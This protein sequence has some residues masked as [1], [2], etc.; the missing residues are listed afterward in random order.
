[1]LLK[2]QQPGGGERGEGLWVWCERGGEGLLCICCIERHFCR[3]NSK[4]L[5]GGQGE[6]ACVWEEGVASGGSRARGPGC[7][8]LER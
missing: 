2:V 1:M 3:R 7:R 6:E 4:G 5:G 8:V